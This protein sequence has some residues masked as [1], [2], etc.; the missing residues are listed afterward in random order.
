[1][2]Q[3]LPVLRDKLFSHDAFSPLFF[4]LFSC[5]VLQFPETVSGDSF[6]RSFQ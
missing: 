4:L 2:P 3:L 5:V 1:M 6:A